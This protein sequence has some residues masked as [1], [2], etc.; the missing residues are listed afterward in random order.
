MSVGYYSR[1]H[2]GRVFLPEQGV[3]TWVGCSHLGRVFSPGQGVLT[4]A[5]CSYLASSG[6][7]LV[8]LNASPIT[9]SSKVS[10]SAYVAGTCGDLRVWKLAAGLA[11]PGVAY[12]DPSTSF[13]PCLRCPVLSCLGRAASA[14]HCSAELYRIKRECIDYSEVEFQLQ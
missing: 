5:G 6:G 9:G 1:A 14:S 10:C 13:H 2:L 3:L 12:R 11:L 4:W 8:K 7:S